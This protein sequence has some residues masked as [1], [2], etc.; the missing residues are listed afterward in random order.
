MNVQ[1]TRWN[2]INRTQGNKYPVTDKAHRL[3]LIK[4]AAEYR[5]LKQSNVSSIS[6]Q[7]RDIDE[8]ISEFRQ[9]IL[10]Y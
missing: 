5:S 3:E 6:Q 1:S 10:E 8:C 7:A 9:I 2:H 4:A